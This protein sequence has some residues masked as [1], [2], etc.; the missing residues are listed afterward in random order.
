MFNSSDV[1]RHENQSHFPPGKE[2]IHETFFSFCSLYVMG[3]DLLLMMS[4][5]IIKCKTKNT[6]LSEQFQNPVKKHK[7]RGKIDASTTHIHDCSLDWYR[8]FN[9]K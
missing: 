5:I 8:Y 4:T 2:I 3:I 6:T 1:N 9:K 7:N